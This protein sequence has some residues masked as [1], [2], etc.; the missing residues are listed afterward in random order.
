MPP[1][2]E[3]GSVNFDPGVDPSSLPSYLADCLNNVDARAVEVR[4]N[5]VTFEGGMFRFVMNW[6][7]LVPFGFGDLTV[8]P[9]T[10][11]VRYCLSYRQFVISSIIPLGIAAAFVFFR[12][13]FRGMSR[14]I[15]FFPVLWLFVTFANLAIGISR[16]EGFLESCV[17]AAPRESRH[18][19]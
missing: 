6:N 1:L 17:A 19:G 3:I 7:V 16:F 5:R 4:G 13:G 8:N 18:S 15:I 2:P 10:H 14:S 11:E 9:E 12:T